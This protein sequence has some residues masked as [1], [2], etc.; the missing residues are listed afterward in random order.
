MY[1]VVP[2]WLIQRS[3]EEQQTVLNSEKKTL[4]YKDKDLCPFISYHD[5]PIDDLHLRIRI[6]LKL[7]NQVHCVLLIYMNVYF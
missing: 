1:F 3:K 6:S 4:G 2:S 7:F 5:M